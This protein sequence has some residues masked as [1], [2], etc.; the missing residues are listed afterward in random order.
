MNWRDMATAVR[1]L[2]AQQLFE[3]GGT[4][5]TVASVVTFVLILLITWWVSRLL[6]GILG[7]G[8]RRG[9][10]TEEG[11]L[12]TVKRLLHYVI[13]LVGLGVALQTVGIN[14]AS[15]FAAGAVVAVAVGFA[16]QN[17][18]QNFASGVILLAE[19]SITEGDVL[20]VEGHLIHVE[21]IGTRATV[22]RTRD[23]EQLIIPNSSLVQSTVK[24]Y[25][26]ADH[27]YRV[28]TVVGVAYGSD[29]GR[30]EEV[31]TEAART[32]PARSAHREPSVLLLEFGD[33]SVLWEVSVWAE[34]PWTARVTR[35]DLNKAIWWALKDASITI[36]FP[37]LDVH[38]D[39]DVS[40][41]LARPSEGL[42]A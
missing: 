36:A 3:V 1:D 14:L 10:L 8:L 28:R 7:R 16:M 20:E 4:S 35:S 31:L 22:A 15:L 23:D 12:A 24:N 37:Q 42:G 26:L 29:Q 32:L 5:V 34:D 6:Q 27:Y 30:A 9:G 39:P 2:A 17:I 33:S 38:F 13:L 18:L 40:E 41:G 21:R 19:R 25:T 11:T